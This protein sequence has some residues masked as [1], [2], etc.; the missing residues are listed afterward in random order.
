MRSRVDLPRNDGTTDFG[1]EMNGHA[2]GQSLRDVL[3][4]RSAQTARADVIRYHCSMSLVG[5]LGGLV[6]VVPVVVYLA[7][8]PPGGFPDRLGE[9]SLGGSFR[10]D[11][12]GPSLISVPTLVGRDLAL[13][14]PSSVPVPQV[15][16]EALRVPQAPASGASTTLRDDVAAADGARGEA[17]A[18]PMASNWIEPNRSQPIGTDTQRVASQPPADDSQ[19]SPPIATVPTVSVEQSHASQPRAAALAA[20]PSVAEA[21]APLMATRTEPDLAAETAALTTAMLAKAREMVQSGAILEA[22]RVLTSPE[23]AERGEALF[24]LAE[25]YDPN[26]LAAIGAI[27]VAADADLARRHYATARDRGVLAAASRLEALE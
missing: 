4:Q 3:R 7:G 25:T 2:T 19:V 17:T 26:V 18:P 20:E 13:P 11:A 8:A 16:T 27:G 6:L 14:V 24:V 12:S 21:V 9:V 23:L 22:R 10:A 5:Y 1:R 15:G